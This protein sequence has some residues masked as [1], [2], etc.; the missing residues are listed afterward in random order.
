MKKRIA[1][2]FDVDL[3]NQRG[4]FNA[5]RSRISFLYRLSEFDIDVFVISRYLPWYL[6]I[7]KKSEL[8]NNLK[9][10][11]FDGI[12]YNIIWHSFSLI[13]YILEIKFHKSPIISNLFY[14]RIANQIKGYDLL[15]VHSLK[16]GSLARNISERDNIPFFVTWHGSDIHTIPFTNPSLLKQTQTILESAECNFFVSETLYKTA[17][18]IEPNIRAE[19]LYNGAN[20]TFHRYSDEERAIIRKEYNVNGTTKV[21]AFVGNIVPV[22]N[23][24][25]LPEIFSSIKSQ[26]GKPI[27]FWIVGDGNQQQDLANAMMKKSIMCR[28][29]GGQTPE[30]MPNIMNCIDILVLPSKNEGLPL[31]TVEALSCGV[32]VVGSCV[33]GIPEVIGS[34]NVFVLNDAFVGN[35][36]DRIIYMLNH[37]VN[38][39]LPDVF[40]WSETAK[41]E[42][43]IYKK[44]H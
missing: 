15:S 30:E 40:D 42:A 6:R 38:Q 1:I 11:Q 16:C 31:V 3:N 8:R 44:C 21:I 43:A 10:I 32:N 29:M 2:L 36:S 19:I 12:E 4:M 41:K 27:Q 22:K 9:K 39:L 35:I 14:K 23:P 17:L 24:L 34:E 5:I 25:L 26:Y 7:F 20:E 13:D 18:L 28:F 33:G 37:K